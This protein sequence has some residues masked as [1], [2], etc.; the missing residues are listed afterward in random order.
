MDQTCAHRGSEAQRR[1]HPAVRVA[2]RE[3]EGCK[4]APPVRWRA[5]R[6]SHTA[7]GARRQL[8][9]AQLGAAA[10]LRVRG[11]QRRLQPVEWVL[12]LAAVALRLA[13][14]AERLSQRCVQPSLETAA[15][16]PR[17]EVCRQERGRGGIGTRA[18]TRR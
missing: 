7:E 15:A 5:C 2:A 17:V 16:R 13:C 18:R 4:G 11:V 6:V 12:L 10:A 3:Q 1:R 9:T 8:P 14:L